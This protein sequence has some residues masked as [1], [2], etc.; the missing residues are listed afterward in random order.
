MGV[1]KTKKQFEL[2]KSEMI[3]KIDDFMKNFN[4]FSRSI[5]PDDWRSVGKYHSELKKF[6][7]DIPYYN[8]ITK[9][10]LEQEW[11]R[12]EVMTE[13]EKEIYKTSKKMN[14]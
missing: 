1:I 3:K 4:D 8:P 9:K 2:M 5:S 13:E 12:Y 11:V 14:I 6:K 10:D 7:E